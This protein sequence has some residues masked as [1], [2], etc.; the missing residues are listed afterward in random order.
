MNIAVSLAVF[1]SF[2][3]IYAELLMDRNTFT[4]FSTNVQVFCTIFTEAW[5]V[6]PVLIV[7]WFRML[8]M[9]FFIFFLFTEKASP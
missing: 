3:V 1:L 9:I 4:L 6:F 5:S 8:T 7:V 2:D